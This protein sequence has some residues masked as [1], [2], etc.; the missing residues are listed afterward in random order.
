[1]KFGLSDDVHKSQIPVEKNL[2][3]ILKIIKS[4][5]TVH[6]K[7]HDEFIKI[8]KARLLGTYQ[9]YLKQNIFKYSFGSLMS[10]KIL[11]LTLMVAVTLMI[12]K[13]LSLNCT[14]LKL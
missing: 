11:N 5:G 13:Y 14:P 6:Y 12:K 9:A 4:I 8:K 1:M 10:K 7:S 2:T 3:W